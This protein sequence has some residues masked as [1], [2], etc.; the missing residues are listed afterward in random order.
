MVSPLRHSMVGRLWLELAN[1]LT[2]RRQ[3]IRRCTRFR[4]C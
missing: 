3:I 1:S 2:Q 4:S